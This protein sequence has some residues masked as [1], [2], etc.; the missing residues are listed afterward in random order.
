KSGAYLPY[1]D[2]VVYN[3][4]FGTPV[5]T[6]GSNFISPS[7]YKAPSTPAHPYNGE[8]NPNDNSLQSYENDTGITKLQYT[9]ALSNSA[10]LR[11]YGY[12]FYSDWLQNGPI[13]GSTGQGTPSLPAAQ[14]DLMTHSSGAALDFNDQI[15]DQNLVTASYN[16]TQAG[17]IRFNNTSA[18]AGAGTTPIGYM[19]NGNCLDAHNGKP[20][21]CISSTYYNVA[22]GK[23]VNPATFY[24]GA[25]GTCDVPSSSSSAPPPIPCGWR[26]NAVVGP[27]GFGAGSGAT[28]NTLWNG[29]VTGSYN[30]VRPRFQNASLAD[31]FRPN[32]KFMINASLR[33]DNFTY[34]MPNVAGASDTFYANQVA[35]YTCV[36]ASTNEVFT[37]PLAPGQVPP[38]NPQYVLGDCNQAVNALSGITNAKGWVHPNGT[39]QDGVGS[40]HFTAT[41]PGSYSIDYWQPR[42]SATF[43]ES[44]DTVWRL[45]A[46]RY[47]APPISASVQYLSASGDNRSTW[48]NMMNLGFYSPFH[49]IPGV[50]SDQYDLS[51]E[52]HITGTDMSLKLT[53]YYTWVNNWQQQTFI[54]AG[55]VTQVP[56][57]VNRDYGVEFQ[58]SKGDFNRQGLSGLF[59]FTY[60]NS[61][62]QFQNTSLSTGGV[63]PNQT[64]ALNQAISQYNAL[65]KGGGGSPCY[66][67]GSP[68]ACN[69]Q[70]IHVSGYEFDTIK[71]PYYNNPVQGLL[72]PNGWYNPYVT[73]ISP[74]LNG[75]VDSYI[76]PLTSTLILNYRHDKWAV[77]PSIQ[78]Q[79]GAWYGSPLDNNGYDPRACEFSS[80]KS[81]I[82]SAT[83]HQCDVNSLYAPGLGPLGYLYTPNFQTGS[84]SAIGSYEAPNIL[85]G[86]L[87]VT[88]DVSPKVKL[89]MTGTNLF[90]MCFAGTPEPWTAANPPSPWACGYSPAGGALNSTL[91]PGNFYNGKSIN[92]AKANSGVVTPWTQSYIPTTGNNGAIGGITTPWNL[93]FN[94]QIKI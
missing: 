54:G 77:T 69:A 63:I 65:T 4:P 43:T 14:Y 13:F 19:S 42:V 5:A 22:L 55:F 35:N 90:R 60:T 45:S 40:P 80:A 67:A 83:P 28:W 78:F 71:N 73:A 57:G 33:Y 72:D 6:S 47:A 85:T 86:N 66:R 37:T 89:T 46:G 17:V 41:S 2:Q 50:T 9:Y 51:Y 3:L 23:S 61:K 82:A 21:P 76:A 18:I 58:F 34:V 52:R 15:N 10:Y 84:F 31:Q 27:T 1:S 25:S 92:D 49:P 64:I 56:V 79:A 53:P 39:V 38:A 24:T 36:Q 7:I 11:A 48:N 16:Y 26:S 30:T 8:I 74:N 20:V 75:I 68:V 62:I 94:A 87:Q 29:E 81:G 59:S 88:Y 32:D 70:P 12:T 91:Y 44:A 93:Y